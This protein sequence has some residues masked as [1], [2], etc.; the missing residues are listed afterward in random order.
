MKTNQEMVRQ[1]GNFNVIQRTSDGY[2]NAT[3]LLRMWN[4][5]NP[6]EQRRLD[7]FWEVTHLD[8]LMSEIAENELHFKSLNFGD[9]KNALSMA[10]RG[11]KNGGTW[12]HPI[13]FVKFAM[14]LSPRFEYHVLKFV[15]DEMIRY[16]NDA[17]DA[18]KE[19]SS[20]IMRIVPK[21]FMPKAMCRVGEALNWVVFGNHE[22]DLRNK[23]GEE[24][25][26]RELYQLEKKV[27]DL[28]NEG[29]I[30]NFDNVINY[31]RNQYQKRNSPQVFNQSVA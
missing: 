13:L 5:A 22:K 18:Y 29:F 19:L 28:I 10:C 1:M 4:S 2:F 6:N 3:G 27:A 15:S 8:K 7:N 14:Y 16:R 23:H 21:D 26:Q 31:L 30:T 25:K 17:G 20:A 24:H 11:K 12:M 9:L